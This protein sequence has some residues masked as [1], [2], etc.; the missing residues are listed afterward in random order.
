MLNFNLLNAKSAGM[1]NPRVPVTHVGMGMGRTPTRGRV[2]GWVW[3]Q[4]RP[5]GYGYRLAKPVGIIPVDISRRDGLADGS[6]A[7]GCPR[8]IGCLVIRLA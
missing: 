1:G 5:D 2:W 8:Y 6:W 7:H 3:V 4:V